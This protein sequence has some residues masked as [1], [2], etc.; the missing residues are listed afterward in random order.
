MLTKREK[1][2]LFFVYQNQFRANLT[3]IANQMMVKAS[4]ISRFIE[5][6]KMKGLIQTVLI[7]IKKSRYIFPLMTEKGCKELGLEMEKPKTRGGGVEH[8]VFVYLIA[9]KFGKNEVL[10]VDMEYH[11][12]DNHHADVAIQPK[13]EYKPIVIEISITSSADDELNNIN[14]AL[15]LGAA[16]VIVAFKDKKVRDKLASMTEGRKEVIVCMI[17]DLL[18]C[19]KDPRELIKLL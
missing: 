11:M 5:S 15:K 6:L 4:S 10:Q 7:A 14:K 1:K 9:D 13:D 17:A 8:I 16:I 3:D 12:G 19:K 2:F 18:D